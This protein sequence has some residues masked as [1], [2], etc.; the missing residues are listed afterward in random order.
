MFKEIGAIFGWKPKSGESIPIKITDISHNQ[1]RAEKKMAPVA[2]IEKQFAGEQK[3]VFGDTG[4]PLQYSTGLVR[5]KQRTEINNPT[6]Y[7]IKGEKPEAR[8]DAMSV[9]L[10]AEPDEPIEIVRPGKGSDYNNPE[11]WKQTGS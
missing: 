7:S 1:I 5:E 6:T 9:E 4:I 8:L 2:K 3:P 11:A 10:G